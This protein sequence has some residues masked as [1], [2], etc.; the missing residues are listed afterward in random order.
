MYPNIKLTLILK[1][2]YLELQR[3]YAPKIKNWQYNNSPMG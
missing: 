1:E 2:K 3:E